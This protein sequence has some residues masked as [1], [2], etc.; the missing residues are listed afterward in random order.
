MYLFTGLASFAISYFVVF[1]VFFVKIPKG[2]VGVVSRYGLF[3]KTLKPGC[4]YQHPWDYVDTLSLQSRTIEAEFQ[5]RTMDQTCIYF[6][7]AA[8][9]SVIANHM[10]MIKR[11]TSNCFASENE[12]EIYVQHLLED[13]TRA[14]LAA[15]CHTEMINASQDVIVQI[16]HN[17]DAILETW[18]YQLVDLRYKDLHFVLI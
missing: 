8:L 17:V 1:I 14:Y 15:K 5:A 16:K 9:F 13:E 11:A 2:S 12:F 6:K 7:Y 3:I 4:H 18:G 10:N